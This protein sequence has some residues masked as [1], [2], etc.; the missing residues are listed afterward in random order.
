MTARAPSALLAVLARHIGTDS[1]GLARHV[2]LTAAE[3]RYVAAMWH[4]YIID[5]DGD[6]LTMMRRAVFADTIEHGKS[7]D[8]ADR[9]RAGAVA[10]VEI[11]RAAR[12]RPATDWQRRRVRA[13][14]TERELEKLGREARR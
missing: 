14:V 2:H 13:L 4:P 11:F 3:L 9:I 12:Q 6:R 8:D 5:S 10:M 7:T 1:E